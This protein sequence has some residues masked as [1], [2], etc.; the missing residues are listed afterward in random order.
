[1]LLEYTTTV[2]IQFTTMSNYKHFA[3]VFINYLTV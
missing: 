3:I 1:M 2:D